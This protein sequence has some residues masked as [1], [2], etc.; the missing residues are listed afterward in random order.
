MAALIHAR[1]DL[2]NRT[3]LSGA[4]PLATN[5]VAPQINR[6]DFYVK[7]SFDKQSKHVIVEKDGLEG[8][9]NVT[10]DGQN[11]VRVTSDWKVESPI[12]SG[13]VGGEDVVVQYLDVLPTGYSLQFLGTKVTNG[14]R[15]FFEKNIFYF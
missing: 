14:W 7:T 12:V 5:G 8:D 11:T 4:G 1:R 6:W 9:F 13:K 10:V 2:R 15:I 3:W